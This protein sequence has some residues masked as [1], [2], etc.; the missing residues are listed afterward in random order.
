MKVQGVEKFEGIVMISVGLQEYLSAQDHCLPKT[1]AIFYFFMEEII[2]Y[3][4]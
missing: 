2:V 4:S 1:D 3:R